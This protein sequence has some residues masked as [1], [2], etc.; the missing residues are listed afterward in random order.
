MEGEGWSGETSW[1]KMAPDLQSALS[2]QKNKWK[3][4]SKQKGKAG[5]SMQL[6]LI[7]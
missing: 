1:R 5:L 7:C 3:G 6:K 2:V 4:S